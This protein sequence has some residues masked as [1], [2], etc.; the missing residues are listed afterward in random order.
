MNLEKTSLDQPL[1][2]VIAGPNGAGKSTFAKQYLY[3]ERGI[4]YCINADLIA[5]GIS[6]ARPEMAAFSAGRIFLQEFDRLSTCRESFAI[7]TTLSGLVYINRFKF[8]KAKGY[9]LEIISRFERFCPGS[10]KGKGSSS[11]RRARHF[12]E[13]NSKAVFS[14]KEKL[15]PSLHSPCRCLASLRQ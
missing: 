9:R 15:S 5:S 2:L 10:K 4:D 14:F 11:R 7:E 6:P 12:T 3:F 13:R 1:C 8:L